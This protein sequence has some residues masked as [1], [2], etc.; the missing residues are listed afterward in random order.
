[1]PTIGAQKLCDEYGGPLYVAEALLRGKL[2]AFQ[3]TFAGEAIGSSV[4]LEAA[5]IR[6]EWERAAVIEDNQPEGL[7]S[8]YS[9]APRG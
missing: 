8:D 1:M 3:Q 9:E 6:I 5:K 7:R 2:D 4:V